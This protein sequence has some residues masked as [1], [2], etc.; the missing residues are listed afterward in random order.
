MPLQE[1][2]ETFTHYIKECLSRNIAY[3]QLVRYLPAMDP[4]IEGKK[5]ATVHDVLATYGPLIKSPSKPSITTKL[6][7]NGALTPR[8][9]NDLIGLNLIDAAVFGTLW[10]GNPDLQTRIEK[11]LPINEK[12]ETKSFYAFP[13][14]DPRVGYS[15]YPKAGEKVQTT[16]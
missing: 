15:D 4:E 14:G 8:E 3:I 2:I 11:G 5:R 6:L 12:P 16:L 9:T 7:L 10:I 13:D 1:A